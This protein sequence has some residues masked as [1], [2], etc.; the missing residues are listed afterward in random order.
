MEEFV[1]YINFNSIKVQLERIGGKIK[2]LITVISI[3]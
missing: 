2:K 1:F 3:P